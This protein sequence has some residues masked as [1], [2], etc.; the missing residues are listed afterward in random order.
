MHHW[1]NATAKIKGK[2][3]KDIQLEKSY[4]YGMVTKV[5]VEPRFI[6]GKVL[7]E[8]ISGQSILLFSSHYF[9]YFMMKNCY[10]LS[11]ILYTSW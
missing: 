1:L 8:P 5:L 4:L 9:V 7:V 3:I 2:K 6:G 11:I 10:F